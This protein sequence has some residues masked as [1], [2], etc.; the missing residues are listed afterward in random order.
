MLNGSEPSWSVYLDMS[1]N[2]DYM[3]AYS[4]TYDS[5]FKGAEYSGLCDKFVNFGNYLT[6]RRVIQQPCFSNSNNQNSTLRFMIPK[7]IASTRA[8]W[9]S[10]LSNNNVTVYGALLTPTY[11]EITDTYLLEQLNGLLDIELY[12]NLCYVD[13][14]GIQKPTMNLQYAGTEDLGIKYIITEDGKKIRTDWRKLGR[15]KKWMMK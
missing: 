3:Y 8:E 6:I 5:Y 4:S 11:T 14:V 9:V 1:V 15:R 7:T 13:W 12:E 2:F 10:W